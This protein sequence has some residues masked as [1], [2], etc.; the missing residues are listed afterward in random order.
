MAKL[1]QVTPRSYDD[2]QRSKDEWLPREPMSNE[3]ARAVLAIHGGAPP[4]DDETDAMFA[5]IDGLLED[6]KNNPN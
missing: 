3:E 4:S 6:I 2:R 1:E 5:E